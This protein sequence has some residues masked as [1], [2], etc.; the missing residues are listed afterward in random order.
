MH[1]KLNKLKNNN[2]D[3]WSN[4]NNIYQESQCVLVA[5]LLV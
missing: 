2:P 5:L 3:Y 1:A 4:H